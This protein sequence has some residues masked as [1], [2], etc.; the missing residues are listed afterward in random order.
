MIILKQ[1]KIKNNNNYTHISTCYLAETK[2][3]K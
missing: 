3:K 1:Q 2:N